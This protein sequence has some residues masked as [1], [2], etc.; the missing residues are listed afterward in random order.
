[1]SRLHALLWDVDGTLAE[2]ECGGHRVAFNLAFEERGLSFRWDEARYGEL[3][4]VAGGRERLI[5]DL[6]ERG[7]PASRAARE[8]LAAAVHRRKN[9]F[10]AELVGGGGLGLRPGV[11][12][13]IDE[14][15]E[16]GLVMGITTTTGRANLDALLR[17][18]LGAGWRRRFAA[19]VTGE[20][21]SRKKPDPEVYTRALR[22]LGL[23]PAAAVAIEDSPDGVRAAREAGV[24]VVVTRSRYF[25]DAPVTGALAV[26][27]GLHTRSGWRPGPPDG[28]RGDDRIRLDDIAAWHEQAAHATTAG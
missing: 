8:A 17:A 5:A 1:M 26:G 10:Y 2:T 20:D 11:V 22:A 15:S 4:R 23:E 6:A 24:A 27:P 13:L 9:A 25:A 28:P 18:Q 16:R 12:E 19:V 14:C 3:L 7:E 21:V